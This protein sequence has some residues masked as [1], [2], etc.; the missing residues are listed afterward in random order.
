MLLSMSTF[1]ICDHNLQFD[2]FDD[3]TDDDNNHG[4]PLIQQSLITLES[5]TGS[6]INVMVF[7]LKHLTFGLFQQ[8]E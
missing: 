1:D 8:G 7:Q 3:N 4:V 5:C 2:N 6:R